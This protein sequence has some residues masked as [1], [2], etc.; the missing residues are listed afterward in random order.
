MP[1]KPPICHIVLISS[2]N[3]GG[4]KTPLHNRLPELDEITWETLPAEIKKVRMQPG[5][6][7]DAELTVLDAAGN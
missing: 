7:Y 4:P 1:K 5:S 6:A 3:P 2:S